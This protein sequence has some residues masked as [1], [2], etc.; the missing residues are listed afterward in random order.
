MWSNQFPPNITQTPD[1]TLDVNGNIEAFL[2]DPNSPQ[3]N[4]GILTAQIQQSSGY[5]GF[6]VTGPSPYTPIFPDNP[7]PIPYA[8]N[9]KNTKPMMVH[10][11]FTVTA[12]TV[13]ASV[14]P[15]LL[16]LT[17][18]FELLPDSSG[19]FFYRMSTSNWTWQADTGNT[20]WIIQLVLYNTYPNTATLAAGG[21]TI[22]T[23]TLQCDQTNR[24]FMIPNL[25]YTGELK[26]DVSPTWDISGGA[27]FWLGIRVKQF[28]ASG[29]LIVAPAQ[30]T[31]G[32][33]GGRIDVMWLGLSTPANYHHAANTGVVN[34]AGY[35]GSAVPAQPNTQYDENILTPVNTMV[36]GADG[37]AMPNV[38]NMLIENGNYFPVGYVDT[39]TGLS[40]HNEPVS[41]VF[42][43]NISAANTSL[44]GMSA[45]TIDQFWLL[46]TIFY[47][48]NQLA[49][50]PLKLSLGQY[51]G[52]GLPSTVAALGTITG[53]IDSTTG[54]KCQTPGVFPYQ[55]SSTF[56]NYI[57]QTTGPAFN[58]I[59]VDIDTTAAGNSVNGAYV[60]L[61][62]C[63]IDYYGYI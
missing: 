25:E 35:N 7:T 19:N 39:E 2:A 13:S 26:Y 49:N 37:N 32:K 51:L 50:V 15:A 21:L 40:G 28:V 29:N 17:N 62:T 14:L 27:T 30:T 47:N 41:V 45:S 38:H 42:K 5:S 23:C 8:K 63:G 48:N 59:K 43:Y 24:P 46:F 6:S 56:I 53:P 9:I 44:V 11:T 12:P 18:G 54:T 55:A 36:Y 1:G 3:P 16:Y 22:A 52:T 60:A 58:F 61:G 57:T 10:D 4:T 20:A 33:F 34:P 31:T